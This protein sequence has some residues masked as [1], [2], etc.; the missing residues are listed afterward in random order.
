MTLDP[1]VRALADAACH[2][3]GLSPWDVLHRPRL[4][5]RIAAQDALMAQVRA[6][7]MRA[8]GKRPR[9]RDGRFV[10]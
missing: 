1:T 2:R 8:Q 4:H 6:D 10:R 9:G 7:A 5:A 3:L